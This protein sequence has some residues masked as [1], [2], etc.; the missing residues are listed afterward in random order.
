MF[1][2]GPAFRDP[3]HFECDLQAFDRAMA[4]TIQAL[5]TGIL[6]TRDGSFTAQSL[7]EYLSSA[8]AYPWRDTFR[9]TG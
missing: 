7:P 2:D 6:K 8:I 9:T 4:D 1:L 5:N 3:F